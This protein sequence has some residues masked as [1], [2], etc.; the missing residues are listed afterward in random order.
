MCSKKLRKGIAEIVSVTILIL[1][2][3]AIGIGFY[4]TAKS[5]IDES[6]RR[7][8]ESIEGTELRLNDFIIV[9][10]FINS[11]NLLVIYLYAPGGGSVTFDKLYINNTL[12]P[13]DKYLS[14]FNEVVG[15]GAL[16]EFVVNMTLTPG[17]TY[18]I[19][20]TGTSG[21]RAS[22]TVYIG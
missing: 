22:A 7:V 18:E 15:A 3:V 17:K 19:L 9:D 11:S 12:V 6:T 20:L 1:I 8:M 10:A 13:S 14:G 4:Y 16:H 5:L 2:A 21:V